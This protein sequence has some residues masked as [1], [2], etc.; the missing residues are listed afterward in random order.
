MAGSNPAMIIKVA[1]N[2]AAL[3]A[4]LKEGTSAI[5]VTTAGMAKLAASLD[6]SKLEQRAHN[7]TAAINEVGGASKLTD[8]EARRLLPTLDAWIEKGQRMGKEIPPDILKTRDALREVDKASAAASASATNWKGMLT[9]AAGAFGVALSVGAIVNFGKSV[10]DSASKIHDL[11]SQ[12]GISTDAV[13]GFK[14]AAEQSGSSLDAVGTAIGKMNANLSGGDKSTVKALEA[15]GLKFSDIRAMKPEDAFLAIS[16]AI[17]GMTDPMKQVEVGRKLMGKGFDELLPAMKEGI[18]ATAAAADKMFPDTIDSLEKAQDAWS[19]L[20][21]KVTIVTGG[22]I[23]NVIKSRAFTAQYAQDQMR[24]GT[25]YANQMSDIAARAAEHAGKIY[26]PF[27]PLKPIIQGTADELAAAAAAAKK[28][29][30]A[31]NSMF[32]KFSGKAATEEMHLLDAVFKKLAASGHITEKQI[33]E[34]VK[35]AIKLQDA[36]ARLTP[37]LWEMAIATDALGPK[38]NTA[39]LNL[40]KLGTQV[41]LTVPKMVAIYEAMN[42]LDPDPKVVGISNLST[43]FA[44]LVVRSPADMLKDV[45]VKASAMEKVFAAI[46]GTLQRAFEGGGGIAGALKSIAVQLGEGFGASM[47]EAIKA[48]LKK[49]LSGI[50]G[51]TI[52]AAVGMGALAAGTAAASGASTGQQLGAVAS[53]TAGTAQLAM[54]AHLSVAASTALAAYTAGAGLAVIAAIKIY[55]AMNDGRKVMQDYYKTFKDGADGLRERMLILGAAGEQMWIQLTQKT[56]KG[57]KAGAAKITAEISKALSDAEG[58][59][60]AISAA[61]FKSSDDLKATADLAMKVWETMRDSGKY[62]ASQ[63]A[64]AWEAAQQAIQDGLGDTAKAQQEIIDTI[65]AKYADSIAALESEY[66]GLSDSVGKEAEEEFMGLTEI[67]ERERMKQ[68]AAEKAAQIIMRD[69]EIAAKQESFAGMLAAGQDVDEALRTLFG[70]PM[71]I[72]YSFVPTNAPD[73]SYAPSGGAGSSGSSPSSGGDTHVTLM[74]PDGDVLL[75]QVVKT[76]KRRGWMQ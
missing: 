6:G 58:I 37:R 9:S 5:T 54:A 67:H 72:P 18:R 11:A 50:S 28:Y 71:E 53:A 35:E 64:A 22:I 65:T 17:Q 48:S 42:K 52:G 56:G 30:D 12:M 73:Y 2:F 4:A 36:G 41:T 57:D 46:L 76:G 15:A 8:V 62:S 1:A 21:D 55:K 59:Q 32:D 10:F 69:A 44:A 60:A 43:A 66:K 24:F 19:K 47:T 13:Q 26:A 75:R 45:T 27:V 51:T 61:G 31:F 29:A 20:L 33:D 40:G 14:F 3:Q 23:A 7:I 70:K 49:G 68:I 34:I 39:E 25:D 63:V 38:L 16:D 74:M